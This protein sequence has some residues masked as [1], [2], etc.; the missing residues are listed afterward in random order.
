MIKL[1]ASGLTQLI[2]MC[3]LQYYYRYIEKIK[4][5][6]NASLIRGNAVHI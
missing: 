2:E 6:P 5:P 1:H 4:V 3:P